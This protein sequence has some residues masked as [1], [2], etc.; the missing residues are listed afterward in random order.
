[1]RT[2]CEMQKASIPPNG[3]ERSYLNIPNRVD[4]LF[5]IV[6]EHHLRIDPEHRSMAPE[7]KWRK[8]N[9]Q[10]NNLTFF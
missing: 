3:I 2:K 9:H 10:K 5:H 8:V 1:M 7:L 6:Q 4:H